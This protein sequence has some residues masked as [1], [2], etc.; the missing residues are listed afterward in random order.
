MLPLYNHIYLLPST[1]FSNTWWPLIFFI[2]IIIHFRNVH[3]W[4]CR[5]YITF[6]NWLLAL[7]FLR[8]TLWISIQVV[9]STNNSFFSLLSSISCYRCTGNCLTIY[10]LENILI[11]FYSVLLKIELVWT[12]MHSLLCRQNFSFVCDKYSRMQLLGHM[13]IMC[14]GLSE[15]VKLI[16]RV[17]VSLY[18]PISNI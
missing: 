9:A 18:I 2:Y 14:L 17:G 11:F 12:L 1:Q 8:T 5:V 4:K 3:K 6:W 7:F 10:Q 15:F 16:S 13:V